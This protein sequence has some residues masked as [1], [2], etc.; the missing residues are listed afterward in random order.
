MAMGLRSLKRK[1]D[2]RPVFYSVFGRRKEEI[3]INNRG[4]GMGNTTV[5]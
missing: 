3:I 5:I 2:V 4:R 1:E